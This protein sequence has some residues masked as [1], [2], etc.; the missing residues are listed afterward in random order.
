MPVRRV[1]LSTL[2][3]VGLLAAAVVGANIL[4]SGAFAG[5]DL[6]VSTPV[7]PPASPVTVGKISVP[8]GPIAGYCQDRLVNAAHIMTAARSLGIGPHTQSI[9]VMTA[10]GESGLR[11]LNYGDVAGADS[12]GL[13]QQRDN[14]AW[15]T[16]ADRMDPYTS[17]LNF[18]T[19]LVS[20]PRWKELTPGQAAH[21]V[22]I[23]ADPNHYDPYW[24][25]AQ[26]IV[27]ALG[28]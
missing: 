20:V 23:N 25:R 8:A 17:A 6:T 19:R 27:T 9:G 7:C 22:Q 2:V 12:R 14:G 15:G 1:I 3:V 16:L 13:F 18:F 21:A 24:G 4:R 28:G 26:V 5:R 11:V 10:L